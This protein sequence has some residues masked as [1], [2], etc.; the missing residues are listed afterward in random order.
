MVR[1]TQDGP[2][3]WFQLMS[4]TSR[5]ITWRADEYLA[6]VKTSEN[7]PELRAELWN[8][9]HIGYLTDEDREEL[10]RNRAQRIT[11]HT[12]VSMLEAKL[13]PKKSVARGAGK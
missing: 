8:R 10:E 11:E 4:D 3:I 7:E 2:M 13:A 12:T 5:K 6:Y 9:G 1:M